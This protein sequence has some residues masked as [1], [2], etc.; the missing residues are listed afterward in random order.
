MSERQI[1]RALAPFARRIGNLASRGVVVMVNAA[2]KMQG[3][4]LR[5]MAGEIKD[6]VE[7][8]EP[9]GLTAHPHPGA[10]AITLFF[11]GDRSHGVV[12]ATPDR[13]FRLRNLAAGEVALYDDLGHVIKLSRGG[14]VVDGG[15][16]QITVINTPKIRCETPLLECTGEIIAH[17]DD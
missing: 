7:H 17:C 5:L 13:R 14:I 4:Q 12:L 8:I 16:Q 2:L 11:G 6:G 3:L 15:G 1:S 9:Y 10:E